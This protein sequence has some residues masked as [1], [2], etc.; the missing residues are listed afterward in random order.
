MRGM[1]DILLFF[2]QLSHA[3][4]TVFLFFW[5]L[6][7]SSSFEDIANEYNFAVTLRGQM[8][9]QLLGD[10]CQTVVRIRTMVNHYQMGAGDRDKQI[11]TIVLH[12]VKALVS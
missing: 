4:C 3:R 9:S 5:E 11:E 1:R 12:H 8:A 7:S 2:L 6:R 10:G